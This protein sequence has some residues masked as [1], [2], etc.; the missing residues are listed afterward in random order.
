[1]LD[2]ELPVAVT[3]DDGRVIGSIDRTAALAVVVGEPD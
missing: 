3:D 1:M 2:T